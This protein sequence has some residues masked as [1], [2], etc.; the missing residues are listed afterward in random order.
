MKFCWRLCNHFRQLFFVQTVK[1]RANRLRQFGCQLN[2]EI[3][4]KEDEKMDE[5]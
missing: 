4:T 5:I 1:M 3:T 2:G